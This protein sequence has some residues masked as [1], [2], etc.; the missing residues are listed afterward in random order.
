MTVADTMS[1]ARRAMID[2]MAEIA[3]SIEGYRDDISGMKAE[4][5]GLLSVADDFATTAAEVDEAIAQARRLPLIGVSTLRSMPINAGTLNQGLIGAFSGG[6]FF[7][8]AHLMPDAMREAIL[9]PLDRSAGI[10]PTERAAELER[11]DAALLAAEVAEEVMLRELDRATGGYTP[12]RRDADPAILLAP[13]G[14]LEAAA[15]RGRHK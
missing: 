8:L 1:G 14:E 6:P 3:A 5:A 2:A 15:D 10:S 13:D 11:I 12:R 7:A 4:R 9:A